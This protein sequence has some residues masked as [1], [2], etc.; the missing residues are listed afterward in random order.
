MKDLVDEICSDQ[1][2][3]RVLYNPGAA[4][5]VGVAD[6][7]VYPARVS[8]FCM[9]S[10]SIDCYLDERLGGWVCFDQTHIGRFF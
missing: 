5:D 10:F 3:L 1:L 6:G 8:Y 7:R 9:I 2:F 4:D